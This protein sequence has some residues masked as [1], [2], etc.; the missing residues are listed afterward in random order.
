VRAGARGAR[1]P[2]R[3]TTP[4]RTSLAPLQA[5]VENALPESISGALIALIGDRP[6]TY[7]RSPQIWAAAFHALGIEATYLPL[8]VPADRLAD[9]I[10]VMR[11]MLAWW[12]ANVTVPYKESVL[13]LLDER[14]PTAAAI[15]AVNTIVRRPDGRL[16]GASTDGSGLVTD[17]LGEHRGAALV[18][19]PY[20]LTVLLIGAGGAA[21]AAAVTL[22]PLL[23]TGTLLVTNRNSDRAADV[24]G[25]AQAV[26]GRARAVTEDE[27]D[28]V[29]PSV[30]VILNASIRGQAG[31]RT[32]PEGWTSLEPYSALAPASPAVLP[33]PGDSIPLESWK[34]AWQAESASDIQVNLLRSQARM[35][36]VPSHAVIYDMIYAPEE[37]TVMR[38]ARLRGLRAVNG[39]FMMIAQA[40]EACVSHICARLIGARGID[41]EAART[42]VTEAMVAA[43]P[44]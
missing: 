44:P 42:A 1:S 41:R 13:D 3:T 5:L 35:L 18:E 36:L 25:L 39:R 40:A 34:T 28:A 8:D 4:A 31:L 15:G 22:A 6:S 21:R 37:T 29:L 12:G 17:L 32:G 43:W 10:G 19:S 24:A 27:L 33:S 14:D 11:R 16:T 30:D 26:G 20:G 23:G 2:R 9:V 38:H 7:S